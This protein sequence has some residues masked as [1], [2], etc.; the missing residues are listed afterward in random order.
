[1]EDDFEEGKQLIIEGF[2]EFLKLYSPY[3]KILT[4]AKLLGIQI[5]GED[6]D[7]GSY[8]SLLG[9]ALQTFIDDLKAAKSADEIKQAID[10]N[11]QFMKMVLPKKED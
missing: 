5:F 7:L 9:L 10:D 2:E 4:G 6:I 3:V 11:E 8:G 1:M